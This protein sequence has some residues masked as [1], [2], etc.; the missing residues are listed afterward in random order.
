MCLA[1]VVS[2][3][4][5]DQTLTVLLHAGHPE[6]T[7]CPRAIAKGSESPG[8]T[9]YHL[10]DMAFVRNS[11]ADRATGESINLGCLVSLVCPWCQHSICVCRSYQVFPF[12]T[13]MSLMGG[14]LLE[15]TKNMRIDSIK[16][17]VPRC[18][19]YLGKTAYWTETVSF[20]SRSWPVTAL[21]LSPLTESLRVVH[22]AVMYIAH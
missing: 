13:P 21:F 15:V 19:F 3:S 12:Y 10:R 18:I 2:V 7:N 20:D 8:H 17:N 16:G 4:D 22:L 5:L 14:K 6:E 1:F 9:V 11:M